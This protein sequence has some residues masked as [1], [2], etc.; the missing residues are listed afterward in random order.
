MF[1]ENLW[2][3][4]GKYFGDKK[5]PMQVLHRLSFTLIID[6]QPRWKQKLP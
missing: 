3:L 5:K 4:F 6:I 1:G 2:N